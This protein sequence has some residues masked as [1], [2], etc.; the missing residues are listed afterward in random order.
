MIV[1]DRTKTLFRSYISLYVHNIKYVPQTKHVLIGSY[2]LNIIFTMFI[3]GNI[4]LSALPGYCE[5]SNGTVGN[6]NT[7]LHWHY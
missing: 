5:S 4:I 2:N 1:T 3:H 7:L 6:W